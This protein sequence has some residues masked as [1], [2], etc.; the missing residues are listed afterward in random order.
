MEYITRFPTYARRLRDQV[1]WHEAIEL[2]H[3]TNPQGPPEV[4]GLSFGELLGRGGM[5][6][7]FQALDDQTG[8][9]FQ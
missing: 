3:G 7:V 2:G 5:C 6:S 9:R 8:D 4:S 1:M